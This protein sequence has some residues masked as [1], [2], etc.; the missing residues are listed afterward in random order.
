MADNPS[1]DPGPTPSIPVAGD[2]VGGAI[3]Q[4]V[5]LRASDDGSAGS[6]VS[7]SNPLPVTD[8]LG[9]TA[10]N[11]TAQST[12]IGA[13]NETAPATDTASSGLNGRLQRIAQRL[14]SLLAV[15]PSALGQTTKAGSLSVTLASNQDALPVTD[16]S[17]SL[18][19]D[20]PVATPV[21]V[22]LSDGASFISTLPVSAASL[23]L[24]TGAALDATIGTTNTEIGGLTETA[25][26]TD[27]A[28]SGL[29]GRLQRIAQRLT[30][31]IALL[32]TSLGQKTMA[33]GL[34][35][36]IASDQTVIPVSDNAGSLTVDNAGTFATQDSQ[37][38][39]DNAAFTDG[40]T[41]VQPI[42]FVFDEVA[43]TALTENDAAAGRIDSKRAQVGVIED[44]TTRGQRLA[45]SA[46]GAAKV[47]GSAVTQPV[48]AASLPL[49]TGA[50]LDASVTAHNALLGAV[51]ETA[52]ASDTASSGLNG[53]L[54][55]IAQRLTTL[56]AGGLPA[57]LGA[58]G[59]LKIEGVAS[60]TVVP[61]S[62][63][64]G[65][66]TVDGTVAVSGT[67]PIDFATGLTPYSNTALSNTK[68]QVKASAGKLYGWMVHNP[69]AATA[70]IQVWDVASG[71]IT[72]GTTPPTYTIP[73]P[74]G[75]SANVMSERGVSHATA[76]N[77]AATTTPTGS[78]APGT[79]L[80]VSLFYI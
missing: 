25:P 75:A 68:Q 47:D 18:T 72:V 61:V 43:G 63:G 6:D 10:A 66:L 69:S 26:G 52:P 17:G 77:I 31:L 51:N 40:T 41:P 48:S 58:N 1:V 57:V 21:A 64:G 80:V 24:P 45:V 78:T 54:Q 46:A 7:A 35:V 33:N 22:R 8:A 34:A 16:N 37:K 56:L 3:Y 19:V 5:K 4:R 49:P 55:R 44:A 76:I 12:L 36:T 29:N 20:A 2:D 42:G 71:S 60:G 53:R 74:A 73:L 67:M 9:S 11:Q 13:V 32:P 23:P 27:T 70:Y 38:I 14:T 30:S 62:D 28:S 79:A 39:A 59:G 65:S 50:A 15:L